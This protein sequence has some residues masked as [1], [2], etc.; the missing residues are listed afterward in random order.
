MAE[1]NH[2]SSK[3]WSKGTWPSLRLAMSVLLRA[4]ITGSIIE[5]PAS[6]AANRKSRIMMRTLP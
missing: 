2:A 3:K 5:A 4:A 6:M 1:R